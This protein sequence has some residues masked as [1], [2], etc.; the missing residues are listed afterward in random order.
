LL[1]AKLR[2]D[3]HG[4]N[5]IIGGCSAVQRRKNLVAARTTA[6]SPS[7]PFRSATASAALVRT[8]NQVYRSK[9]ADAVI[10]ALPRCRPGTTIAF[11][12]A[13]RAY[14]A[15]RRRRDVAM[16]LARGSCTGRR[17]GRGSRPAGDRR[18]SR[19]AAPGGGGRG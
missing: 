9:G 16:G 8:T 15:L 19:L 13:S 5:Y 3:G 7:P 12:C 11:G 14:W 10:D 1:V 4:H 2:R 6:C 17:D 18:R